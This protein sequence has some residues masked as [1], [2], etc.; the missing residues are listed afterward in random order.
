[1]NRVLILCIVGFLALVLGVVLMADDT[2]QPLAQSCSG[3]SAGGCSGQ[4]AA[5]CAGATRGPLRG[6]LRG[7]QPLRRFG[8]RLFGRS[9]GG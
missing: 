7:R 4:S 9:C 8:A 2:N 5:G 1:M 3:V 6:L